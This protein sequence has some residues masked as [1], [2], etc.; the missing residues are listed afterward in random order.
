MSYSTRDVL[1]AMSIMVIKLGPGTSR[2]QR[3]RKP[4]L[5]LNSLCHLCVYLWVDCSIVSQECL[6]L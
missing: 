1:M 6:G 5:K 4:V 3:G 2:E